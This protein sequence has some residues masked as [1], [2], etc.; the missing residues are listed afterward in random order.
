MIT[1]YRRSL[2]IAT[3]ATTCPV[4]QTGLSS[5][6]CATS[7]LL[8]MIPETTSQN[9]RDKGDI[10]SAFNGEEVSFLFAE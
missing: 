9:M 4:S 10:D 6:I 5:E 2:T 7:V 1:A 8:M 3:L